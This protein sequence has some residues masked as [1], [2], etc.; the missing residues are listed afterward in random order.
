M[1]ELDSVAARA[2]VCPSSSPVF[3]VQDLRGKTFAQRLNLVIGQCQG[4][5]DLLDSHATTVHGIAS[6][7]KQQC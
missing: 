6:V 5:S 3:A 1:S 4:L 2:C 7:C